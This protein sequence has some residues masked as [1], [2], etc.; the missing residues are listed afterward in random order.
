M[1]WIDVNTQL[2][3]LKHTM[4]CGNKYSENCLA[5][6][7]EDCYVVTLEAVRPDFE[8]KLWVIVQSDEI[9]K[10]YSGK[11]VTHWM[12]LPSLP[13]GELIRHIR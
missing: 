10:N 1:E 5:T 8:N 4:G 11:D 2:P 7:G 12:P 9:V 3:E 6:D 13:N